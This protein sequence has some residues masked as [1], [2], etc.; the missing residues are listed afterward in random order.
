MDVPMSHNVSIE[1]Q[2]LTL[3]CLLLLFQIIIMIKKQFPIMMMLQE[4]MMKV[5]GGKRNT[6]PFNK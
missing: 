4:V 5:M 3:L 2:N 1:V 6:S